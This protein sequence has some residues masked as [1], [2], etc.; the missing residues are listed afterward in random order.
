MAS[1]Y[2]SSQANESES[3]PVGL[4]EVREF[5]HGRP[6]SFLVVYADWCGA[7]HGLFK[8]LGV[9]FK[10][11][12]PAPN[13]FPDVRFAEI[14]TVDKHLQELLGIKYFPTVI[15]FIN[16][17]PRD[18]DEGEID[19]EVKKANR[20]D[21][22][23]YVHSLASGSKRS[24]RAP[25]AAAAAAPAV[26]IDIAHVEEIKNVVQHLFSQLQEAHDEIAD[27]KAQLAEVHGE[28]EE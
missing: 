28:M 7:C 22:E 5:V 6:Q 21:L 17:Q 20:V 1:Y 3:S 2:D 14:D 27:L 10:Q 19:D 26:G 24:T 18:N 15:K 25:G 12:A 8:S 9:P 11:G 4:I 13:I 23:E 16:G